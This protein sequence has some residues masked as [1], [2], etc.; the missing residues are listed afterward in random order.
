MASSAEPIMGE[1]GITPAPGYFE[2]VKEIIIRTK[3]S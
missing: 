1:A 3:Y 2:L